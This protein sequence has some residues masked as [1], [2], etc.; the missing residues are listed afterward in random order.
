MADKRMISRL[1]ARKAKFLRMPFSAQALYMH[2][3]LE[4]DDEGIAEGFAT[5]SLIRGNDEDLTLLV[6]NG[7]LAILEPEELV[8]YITGWDEFNAIRKD[9][10]RE[11]SY[12]ALLEK[13]MAL[14]DVEVNI[15]SPLQGVKV[16]S[17]TSLQGVKVNSESSLQDSKVNIES[18]LHS[19]EQYSIGKNSIVQDSIVQ[20]RGVQS[21]AA[22]ESTNSEYTGTPVDNSQQQPPLATKLASDESFGKVM[23]FY[24]DNIHPIPNQV[25]ADDLIS[26]YEE[27]GE[28]W[29]KQAIKEA[30]RSNA[31]SIKYI[32]AILK[33][34][35]SRG[36]PDPWN[37]K[38]PGKGKPSK[39]KTQD[40]RATEAYR[41]A[42]EILEAGG[43]QYGG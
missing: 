7:L 4:A 21:A 29:L 15:E 3:C 42:M 40:D 33:N 6:N 36:M 22:K 32:I 11:S 35:Y 1:I 24:Q 19:I 17:E 5:V 34:W 23:A 27:Y 25:E 10:K 41:G 26:L 30:A 2:L 13:Y 9:T 31:R 43:Y 14:Q 37:H 39:E 20:D 12:H 28:E 8:V 18:P 16:N 38:P